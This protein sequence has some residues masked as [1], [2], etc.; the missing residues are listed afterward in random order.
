MSIHPNT[1]TTPF[2]FH[3]S[4]ETF[5]AVLAQKIT[6]PFEIEEVDEIEENAE[7]IWIILKNGKVY[8]LMFIEC[9]AELEQ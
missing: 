1:T 8:S 3:M 5:Y 6:L 2:F 7:T 9:E 4:T